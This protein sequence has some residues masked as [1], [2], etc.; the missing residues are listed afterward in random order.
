MACCRLTAPWYLAD[1]DVSRRFLFLIRHPLHDSIR[2][3]EALDALLTVAAFEQPLTLVFLDE[4][5]D[6]LIRHA[7]SSPESSL[8][9]L[10]RFYDVGSVWIERESAGSGIPDN[11]SH[12]LPVTPIARADIPALIAR[13][14]RVWVV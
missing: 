9:E 1:I 4:G 11:H 12:E 13:H 5:V 7:S 14:D 2:G 3:T 10:L 6:Q 8:L